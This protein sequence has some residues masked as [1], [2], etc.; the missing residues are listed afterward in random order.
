METKDVESNRLFI[1]GL[2]IYLNTNELLV[3]ANFKR[4]FI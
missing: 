1:L 4:L 2:K 3:L